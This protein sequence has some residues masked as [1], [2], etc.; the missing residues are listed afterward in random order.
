MMTLS[1]GTLLLFG[2][3]VIGFTNIVVDPATIFE[4]VRN[5]VKAWAE[6]GSKLAQFFDHMWA[7]YQ[8][9]GFWVG[10]ICGCILISWN[11]LVVF[12]CGVAGSY[13]ATWGATHLTYLEAQS[14]ILE[15]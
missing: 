12:A 6:G 2:C 8:C 3:A 4:P 5:K 10:L 13:I 1:L 15:K 7:C 14:V 9:T 11:P